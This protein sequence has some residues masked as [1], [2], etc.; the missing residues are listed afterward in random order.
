MTT[1]QPIRTTREGVVRRR[2]G[3][4]LTERGNGRGDVRVVAHLTAKDR[5][6]SGACPI[7]TFLA[8]LQYIAKKIQV[9]AHGAILNH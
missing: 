5:T 2:L 9:L 3:L 7:G 4:D 1:S 8:V 6:G